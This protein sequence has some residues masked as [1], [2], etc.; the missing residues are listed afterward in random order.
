[1][2]VHD[3]TEGCVEVVYDEEFI[4]GS[5]LQGTC[6]NFRGKLCVWNHLLK[7]SAAD[8]KGIVDN[9]V[10]L[11]SGKTVVDKLMSEA[12]LTLPVEPEPEPVQNTPAGKRSQSAPKRDP[13]N[14]WGSP[15]RS[16]S[17][18]RNGDKQAGWREA[19]GPSEN[20]IGFNSAV[21]KEKNGQKAWKKLVSREDS[22]AK[23]PNNAAS[24]NLKAMLG[25][26]MGSTSTPSGTNASSEGLKALIGVGAADGKE[27]QISEPPSLESAADALMQLMMKDTPTLPSP[28]PIMG[29][30]LP[31]SAFN[32]TYVKEGEEPPQ[33]QPQQPLAPASAYFYP[34]GPPIHD[35]PPITTSYQG[36]P[37]PGQGQ[38]LSPPPREPKPRNATSSTKKSSP[39]IP[40][41]VV[42]SKK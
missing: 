16:S 9:V 37:P 31:N 30:N 40:S 5:T 42:K 15:Q 21:R 29:Q 13:K 18:S 12:A 11:G 23:V 39:M 14:A 20:G 6:A 4:G 19:Q 41:V 1:V 2:A 27:K 17:T 26:K 7:I 28:P 10:P 36:Y 33:L 32:F 3:A 8:S 24:D 35:M 34:Q 22:T 38:A 25:V